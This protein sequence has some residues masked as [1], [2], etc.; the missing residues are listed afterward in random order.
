M[1]TC[2]HVGCFYDVCSKQTALQNT[3][4]DETGQYVRE[5]KV[6]VAV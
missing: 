3:E 6:T 1:S 5:G 4:K 2:E